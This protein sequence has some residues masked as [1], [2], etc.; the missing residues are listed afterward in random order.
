MLS[1]SSRLLVFDEKA[2]TAIF[3]G[4]PQLVE[5]FVGDVDIDFHNDR[6]FAVMFVKRE[7]FFFLARCHE[8]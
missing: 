2:T 7:F 1:A 6:D 4:N 3:Q 8:R 5:Y